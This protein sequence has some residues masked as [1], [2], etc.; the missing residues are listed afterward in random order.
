MMQCHL[1]RYF[2]SQKY[3][4]TICPLKWGKGGNRE[5]REGGL[6]IAIFVIMYPYHVLSVT[7]VT[8]IVNIFLN[9]LNRLFNVMTNKKTL[10]F[11]YLL[12]NISITKIISLF[13]WKPVEF[14]FTLLSHGDTIWVS[15]RNLKF[16][17]ILFVKRSTLYIAFS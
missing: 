6:K 10:N 14:L 1:S 2:N 11:Y 8:F 12:L 16:F 7:L 9:I 4:V 15:R 13:R 5:M 3:L 17:I